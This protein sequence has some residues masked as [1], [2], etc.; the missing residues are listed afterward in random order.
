MTPPASGGGSWTETV[1]YSFLDGSNGNRRYAGVAIDNAETRTRVI[2]RKLR[3]V[4][5]VEDTPA[6]LS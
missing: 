3:D 2:Q 4:E 5:G 6:L 1:L